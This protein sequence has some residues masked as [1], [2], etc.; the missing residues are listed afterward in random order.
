MQTELPY[1]LIV[2]KPA[3]WLGCMLIRVYQRTVATILPPACRFVPSC[4]QYTLEALQCHGLFKGLWLGVRRICRCHPWHP[5]GYD[6][7]PQHDV[8]ATPHKEA[9][10]R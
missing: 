2:R 5:G 6:P 3:V 7:V 10:A 9:H 1:H 4:S 8:R